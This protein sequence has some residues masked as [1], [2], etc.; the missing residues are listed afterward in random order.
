M[1]G[2]FL[3]HGGAFGRSSSARRSAVTWSRVAGILQGLTAHSFLLG[4]TCLLI[5]KVTSSLHISWWYVLVD[6]GFELFCSLCGPS[7]LWNECAERKGLACGCK[8]QFHDDLEQNLF[9]LC[10][11]RLKEPPSNSKF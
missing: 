9:Q 6:R 2:A 4:F 1:E 11:Q 10:D 3:G 7:N 5:V 8:F